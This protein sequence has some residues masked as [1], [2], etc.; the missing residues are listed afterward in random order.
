MQGHK[1]RR[2]IGFCKITNSPNSYQYGEF[3]S[4]GKDIKT[5]LTLIVVWVRI[6]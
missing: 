4:N 1:F 3:V 6:R 2:K 5:E